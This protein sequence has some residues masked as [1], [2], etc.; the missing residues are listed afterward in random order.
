MVFRL[1]TPV[2]GERLATGFA[3]AGADG[4]GRARGPC[5]RNSDPACRARGDAPR[6]RPD[7]IETTRVS[8]RR[9]EP[10]SRPSAS[11]TS[12]PARVALIALARLLDHDSRSLEKTEKRHRR[13]VGLRVGHADALRHVGGE[14]GE[15]SAVD[16]AHADGALR[17]LA[18]REPERIRRRFPEADSHRRRTTAAR[19]SGAPSGPDGRGRSRGRPRW[20]EPGRLRERTCR[21]RAGGRSGLAAPACRAPPNRRRARRRIRRR[22]TVR[23][24][25]R[26]PGASSPFTMRSRR[27]RYSRRALR[28]STLASKGDRSGWFAAVACVIERTATCLHYKTIPL[29][30][31]VALEILA[32][33]RNEV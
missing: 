16:E 22:A 4:A 31:A 5:G 19:R 18:R 30:Q 26:A 3:S 27:R 8:D 10:I 1:C 7:A 17:P 23:P 15:R 21:S 6:P 20:A 28:G 33:I 13:E 14:I 2:L 11:A 32:W 12:G 25:R 9:G 24:G 29:R